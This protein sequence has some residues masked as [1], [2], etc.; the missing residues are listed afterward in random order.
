MIHGVGAVGRDVH[1]EDGRLALARDPLDRD[2]RKA[3]FVRKSG[4]VDREVN[5][6]EQ[7]MG[8]DFH[9]EITSASSHGL[10]ATS[11]EYPRAIARRPELAALTQTVPEIAHRPGRKAEYHPRR[12]SESQS[13]PRPCR[14]QIPK[15]LLHR[16]PRSRTHLD[17]PCR[18]PAT[19]SIRWPCSCGRERRRARPCRRRKCN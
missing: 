10:R 15:L 18:T 12:T 9:F 16:N 3:K 4:V 5:E 19:R 2:P 17:R 11:N 13:A 14:R 8:R 7:P 6:V 1:L